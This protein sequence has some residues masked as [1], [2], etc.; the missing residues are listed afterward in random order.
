[1]TR[2]RAIVLAIS[3]LVAAQ[4]AQAACVLYEHSNFAGALIEVPANRPVQGMPKDLDNRTSSIKVGASC[5]LVAY[6]DPYF[7]GPMQTWGPGDYPTLPA[8]WDDVIS[9]ARCNCR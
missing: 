9:S 6:H 3:P 7:K 1:M 4:P 5:V 8:D 2:F